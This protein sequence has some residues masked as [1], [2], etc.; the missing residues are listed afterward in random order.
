M[1]VR[2]AVEDD[3]EALAAMA[4]VPTSAMAS[5]VHDRTVLV[6]VG[7][8]DAG[9]DVGG[10]DDP[11]GPDDEGV[12]ARG[13]GGDGGDPTDGGDPDDSGAG[14]DPDPAILGLVGYDASPG[15]V[16]VTQLAGTAAACER[17]LEEPVAFARREGMDVEL[18]AA[19]DEADVRAAAEATGFEAA[20]AG[21]EFDGEPTVTYRLEP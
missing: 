8:A 6:A 11:D 2:D 19:E 7:A 16:H 20:G 9:G 14:D 5:I 15:V 3:A 13:S 21:P 17:L 10:T 4:G 12:G 18:I 1:E